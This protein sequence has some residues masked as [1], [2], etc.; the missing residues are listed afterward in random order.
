MHIIF[1]QNLDPY[2][3]NLKKHDLRWRVDGPHFFLYY[4][5]GSHGKKVIPLLFTPSDNSY[6]ASGQKMTDWKYR[7]PV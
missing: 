6:S 2:C 3:M 5:R 7:S 1:I 4:G